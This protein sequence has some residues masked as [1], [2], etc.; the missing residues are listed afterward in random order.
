[1]HDRSR[2]SQPQQRLTEE[3]LYRELYTR[4]RLER[5]PFSNYHFED[6]AWLSDTKLIAH[7]DMPD[8]W[9]VFPYLVN[10]GTR[11][12]TWLKSLGAR[13][14][15]SRGASWKVSPDRQWV[16]W[17]KGS[18]GPERICATRIDGS[19]H[20][21]FVGD[22]HQGAFGWLPG[23]RPFYLVWHTD[24]ANPST[25]QTVTALVYRLGQGSPERLIAL[26]PLRETQLAGVAP[27]G[28]VFLLGVP[29]SR[30]ATLARVDLSERSARIRRWKI[31]LP[32]PVDPKRTRATLSPD[33]HR[34]AW[35]LGEAKKIGVSGVQGQDFRLW[36]ED[37]DA[38][39]QWVPSG[40]AVSLAGMSS[41]RTLR[42]G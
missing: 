23:N 3:M 27:D 19:A 35:N 33:G 13:I 37:G 41:L 31:G 10:L 21:E 34:L 11:R 4:N 15:G 17:P 28:A 14:R 5:N 8:G 2:S 9:L 32:V 18:P 36:D 42:V 40:N 26:P 24:E 29:E 22:A 25:P 7:V 39:I 6:P 30:L 16:L 38:D 12:I 1:M 20:T